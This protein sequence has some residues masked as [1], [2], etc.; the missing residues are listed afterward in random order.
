MLQ[1][2]PE[3]V[4]E[5][6]AAIYDRPG[7]SYHLSF[8]PKQTPAVFMKKKAKPAVAVIREEGSNGDREMASAFYQAG[9]E[10]WDVTMTDLLYERMTLSRV[11]G[12]SFC[13]RIQLC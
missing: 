13:R 12:D 11:Q 3:C 6:K 8:I 7:P 5:E 2:N 4:L 9:F 1:A 10:P